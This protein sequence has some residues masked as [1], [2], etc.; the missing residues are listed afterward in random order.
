MQGLGRGRGR[1]KVA[2]KE[3]AAKPNAVIILPT[4]E[5]VQGRER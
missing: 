2:G 5:R 3:V 4:G 1:E